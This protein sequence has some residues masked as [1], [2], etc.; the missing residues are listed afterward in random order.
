MEALIRTQPVSVA[1][2]HPLADGVQDTA[3]FERMI[4][5][6]PSLP[7]IAYVALSAEAFRAVA[8]LAR[9]GLEHVV[10]QAHDDSA[11][12]FLSLLDRVQGSRLTGQLVNALRPSLNQLPIPV[13]KTV[14]EVFAEPH[15]YASARAIAINAKVPA[16][17]LYRSFRAAD[18]ASPK[19]LLIAARLLRAYDYLSDPGCSVRG[20][21]RKVGYRHPRIFAA[22]A[23]EVFELS[24]SRLRSYVTEDQAIGRLLNWVHA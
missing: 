24:P 10:L 13:V 8:E 4:A 15:L 1:V 14:E 3:R 9:R 11:E 2:V 7:V 18:L 17:R 6:Y 20:I 21:S 16:V 22:H 12:R 19:K 23:F 5:A